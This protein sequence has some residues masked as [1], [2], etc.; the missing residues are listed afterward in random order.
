MADTVK[1]YAVVTGANKGIGFGT[2]KQ[3]ASNGIVVVLT[4][5]DEKRGLEAL[6]K[7]KDFGIS[8]LVVFHQLDVTDSVSAARLAD[9][10][11]TQFGKLDILVNNAAVV[12]SIVTPEDFKSA[13]SGK[14]PEEINW[15]EIPTIPNDEVAEQCL[16]TNY[17]GTKSVTEALLPLLQLSDSPRIVN[18]SSGVG[19]L[20]NFP[21]GWA[22]EVL[23][24]AERLTEE[25]IDSVLIRFLE[26][27]KKG[28]TKIWSPIFPPYTVSK[29]ALNAYTRILAKK[30][31]NFCINCVSPGFVKT[32]ITFNVGILTIDEGAESLVRLGLLPNGGPTGLYF[33]QKEVASYAV[34]TGA[35]K[36]VGFGTVKQLASKGV[37]VVLTARDEKRGLEALEKLKDFGISDLVVFHQLDVTDSASAAVL[38]DFV[39][40]Q[41]GKL[42]ILV[43]NA[44]INGSVVNPEA[45]ISAATAKKPEEIN[46]NEIPTIPNYELAEE[47]LKTNYYGTKRVTEALLPLLQLSDS[48]RIV[49][50]STGAA[51]LMNFPNGWPKEV[52]SDA[53]TLT[54]ERIDS[55]LSGFLEDSKRGL[56][57]IKIWPPVF[58]PY[59]V[60]KAALNAYTRIL[61]KKYPNFCINCGS[62]GF[63][64][65]DMSF[66]AGILTIDEGAESIVRLALLPN[67]GST[68]LYFSRKEVAPF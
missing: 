51:K 41:F 36:G 61:A 62:P 3:L 54:E 49:N 16:K 45:F 21:N 15:S 18:V 20:M 22:K 27:F 35:N 65:T 47:C 23:S 32:D 4:A 7:L 60:S 64:K 38:A 9:F 44:A 13:S 11:K 30:Y 37:V 52:L 53:E 6:E 28:D 19:K 1:R 40:T 26:D 66:N 63:V 12:G 56:Q 55:V 14:R 50:V 2:V 33:G 29:A 42:D 57:D 58:P 48:P 8:D 25:K 31:P 5:R 17:Y 43:N 46:W 67:G 34:V 59:T 10:V 39:K 24:D 68:G